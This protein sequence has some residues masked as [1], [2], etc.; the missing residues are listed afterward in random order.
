[1]AENE[2]E[3]MEMNMCHTETEEGKNEKQVYLAYDSGSA[4][5]TSSK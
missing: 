3:V 5:P 4:D 1:M 2:K